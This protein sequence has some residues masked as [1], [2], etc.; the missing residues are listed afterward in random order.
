MASNSF[1]CKKKPMH[2]FYAPDAAFGLITLN[3][4][5]SLHCSR[6]LRLQSGDKVLITNGK[7]YFFDAIIE[8]P[9]PKRTTVFCGVGRWEGEKTFYKVH[10]AL[11]PT[12]N[13]ERTEWFVEKATEIGI[14]KITIFFSSHSERR[15]IKPE[16]LQRTAL[17]AMKQSFRAKLPEFDIAG[18]FRSIIASATEKQR[19][20]AW[21][22]EGV[23]LELANAIVPNNDV[24]VLI[25][26]EGDFSIEEV[27][28]A[29]D[30]GFVPVSLGPS[31]L[32]TE[33]AAFVACHT[34]H[35]INLLKKQ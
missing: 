31:R 27:A 33:T 29:K 20:I 14:D 3:E 24:M 30:H 4:D 15:V 25:G 16:R 9:H 32:R 18:D 6:V 1:L 17:A 28:Q 35:L 10:I 11:A 12:K 13:L 8:I 2:L 34:A 19:F 7:G 26:P 5:E 23:K 22:N 21:I